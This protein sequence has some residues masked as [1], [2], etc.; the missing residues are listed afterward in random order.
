VRI[1][2][3]SFS[4]YAALVQAPTQ[5]RE[6]IQAAINRLSLQQRTAIGSAILTSLESIFEEP[7]K[8]SKDS[9][10]D[11]LIPESQKQETDPGQR[12]NSPPAAIILLSDGR[13]TT[14][15][16]PLDVVAEAVSRGVR[17]YTVGV[18][19]PQGAMMNFDGYSMLCVR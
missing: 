2:I 14:G 19:S 8:P 4:G 3:V 7:A 12:N 9:A 1:G 18:G 15:P 6:A 13:N 10:S 17:I 11:V 5:D 16:H